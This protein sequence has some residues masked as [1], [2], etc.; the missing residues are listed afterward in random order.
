MGDI[1][2][3]VAGNNSMALSTV[4]ALLEQPEVATAID[5]MH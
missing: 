2:L 4:K 3:G 5:Y 1:A